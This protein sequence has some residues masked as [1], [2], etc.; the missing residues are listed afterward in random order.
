TYLLDRLL[1]ADLP[2]VVPHLMQ[3]LQALAALDS[4]VTHLMAALPSL[5]NILRYRDVRQTDASA[6]SHVVN[7]M[8]T[9][10]C[11]GL[12]GACASLN[13][14]AAQAM[15]EAISRTHSAIKRL[16]Q[17]AQG[18][19]WS[20]TLVQLCNRETL[21]GLV[22][23]YGCRLLL[24]E[25]SFSSTEAARR[26]NLALSLS[27]EPTHAAAWVEGFLRGSGLLLLHDDS[28]WQVLDSWLS[29]LPDQSFTVLLPLLRRTFSNFSMPERRQMGEHVLRSRQPLKPENATQ[30]LDIDR[31]NQSLTVLTKLLGLPS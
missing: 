9:R 21:H 1:L 30:V 14:E 8:V 28:I 3:R 31:A 18:E 12:P 15:V 5:V 13:D 29:E 17:P 10:V 27:V 22:A 20:H 16:R 4:D 23:G 19:A 2:T 7:G 26:L 25:G 11:I 6:V 24:D